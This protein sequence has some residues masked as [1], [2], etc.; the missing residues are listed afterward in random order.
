M[1][2]KRLF[3]VKMSA[4]FEPGV[5]LVVSVPMNAASPCVGVA[6]RRTGRGAPRSPPPPLTHPARRARRRISLRI[7]HLDELPAERGEDREPALD[8]ADL[9]QVGD[10]L[11]VELVPLLGLLLELESARV[12]RHVP[13]AVRLLDLRDDARG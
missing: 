12:E 6:A 4:L 7:F 9:S 3:H 5:R 11:H 1:P 2:G 8:A 10:L 13:L